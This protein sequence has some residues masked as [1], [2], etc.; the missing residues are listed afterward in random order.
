VN[1]KVR[2]ECRKRRINGQ[3]QVIMCLSYDLSKRDRGHICNLWLGK[4]CCR[5]ATPLLHVRRIHLAHDKRG[6]ARSSP[7]CPPALAVLII[8]RQDACAA[9]GR[10]RS[11]Q[12]Q[13]RTNN[14]ARFL[15]SHR[16]EGEGR[17]QR[18]KMGSI[19]SLRNFANSLRL[20]AGGGF[21]ADWRFQDGSAMETQCPPSQRGIRSRSS[22]G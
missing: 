16:S 1:R 14:G 6:R 8:Q 4:Q 9:V 18:E 10:G 2:L 5:K 7:S 11:S 17:G 12:R 15:R 22:A 19:C 20:P 3:A 13:P 21:T